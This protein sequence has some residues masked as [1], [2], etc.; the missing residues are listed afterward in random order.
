MRACVVETGT[1]G[2]LGVVRLIAV[3]RSEK[4]AEALSVLAALKRASVSEVSSRV[5]SMRSRRACA[6]LT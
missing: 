3:V 2:D 5:L 4:S 1:A 6:R